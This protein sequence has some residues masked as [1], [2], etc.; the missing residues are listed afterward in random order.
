M[1]PTSPG[2]CL[3]LPLS[4]LLGGCFSG[5]QVRF[6]GVENEPLVQSADEVEILHDSPSGALTI[7]GQVT[8]RCS[9]QGEQ[10]IGEDVSDF[11][12]YGPCSEEA[13]ESE[14][15]SEIARVGGNVLIQPACEETTSSE[16]KER[17]EE[18]VTVVTTELACS[19]RVGRRVLAPK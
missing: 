5:L 16:L 19:G 7:I 1:L 17:N 13:M 9:A 4:T 14:M 8:G 2:A 10:S 15:C 3:I 11:M 12:M 6:D 18:Q